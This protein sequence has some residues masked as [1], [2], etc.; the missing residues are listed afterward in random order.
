MSVTNE[1]GEAVALEG[2]KGSV[3]SR[4]V[5]QHADNVLRVESVGH[6]DSHALAEEPMGI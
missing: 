1:F 3:G 4:L 6:L 2:G 5:L